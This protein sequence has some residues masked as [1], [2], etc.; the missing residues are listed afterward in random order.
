M[1]LTVVG[2]SGSVPGPDSPASS[3]L[4]EADGYRLLID[5]GHGAFGALQHHVSPGDVDAIFV[6]HLHADH[7]IDLTAYVVGLRYGGDG[8]RSGDRRI[9]L[10]GVAGTRDRL[11]TAY[12]P[13]ARK[14][15]TQELFSFHTATL[16]ELG[17]F[18]MSYAPMNHPTPTN[19]VRV[20]HGG[21]SLV[22]SGDTG[23]SPELVELAQGADVL[24][25]EAS[26]GPDETVIPNLHLTGRQAGE[27]AHRAGVDRLIVTH[28]PPWNSREV[29][30]E[31]A[32]TAF[33]GVL[34]VAT[35]GAVYEI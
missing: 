25:C 30:G 22:Y 29:A 2:C 13:M 31:Q 24:L 32:A 26:V 18:R 17:P 27:H 20:E 12:D 14:P 33:D 1:K 19:A 9:P 5:L 28:V 4:L 7:C 3:Y 34:D 16:G 11:E 15:G 6:S 21:R 35:A 23:E 8:F 10:I